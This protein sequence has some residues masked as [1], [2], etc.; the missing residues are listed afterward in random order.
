MGVDLTIMPQSFTFYDEIYCLDCMQ[1]DRQK[2]LWKPI[3][4]SGDAVEVIMPVHCHFAKNEGG[5]TCFGGLVENA[6]GEPLTLMSARQL[7]EIISKHELH[8][9]NVWINA[10]LKAMKPNKPIILYWH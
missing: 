4:A 6:Y 7:S 9:K 2:E 3:E 1:F 5:E 10:A 8:E